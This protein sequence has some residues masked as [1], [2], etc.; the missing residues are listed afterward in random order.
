[1]SQTKSKLD[2]KSLWQSNSNSSN[3]KKSSKSMQKQGVCQKCLIWTVRQK[4]GIPE[5]WSRGILGPALKAPNRVRG[6]APE[7]FGYLTLKDLESI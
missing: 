3:I 4:L 7:N 2:N 1:M 5:L 6:K